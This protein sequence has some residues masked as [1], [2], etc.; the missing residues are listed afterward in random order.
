MQHLKPSEDMCTHADVPF[1]L[2]NT[3]VAA[4][5]VHVLQLYNRASAS[6]ARVKAQE[7]A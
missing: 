6:K 5:Q 7:N 3:A 1:L 2:S 4:C